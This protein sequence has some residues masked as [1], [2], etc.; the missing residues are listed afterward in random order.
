[1]VKQE[2][3]IF[4]GGTHYQLWHSHRFARSSIGAASCAE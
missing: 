3:H 4:I 2:K 1:L